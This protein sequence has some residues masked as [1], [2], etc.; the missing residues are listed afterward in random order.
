MGSLNL[1]RIMKAGLTKIELIVRITDG[2]FESTL[3][4]PVE[5]SKEDREEFAKMWIAAMAMAMKQEQVKEGEKDR[6]LM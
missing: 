6:C 2:S 4:I 5:S 3:S 1:R